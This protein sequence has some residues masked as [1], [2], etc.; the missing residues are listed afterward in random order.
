M[1]CSTPITHPLARPL[2]ALLH[3]RAVDCCEEATAFVQ[4]LLRR[5]AQRL[6]T[7]RDLSLG[8]DR[9]GANARA[10]RTA[11]RE[12]DRALRPPSFDPQPL[13]RLGHDAGHGTAIHAVGTMLVSL[14]NSVSPRVSGASSCGSAS[15]PTP[16]PNDGALDAEHRS[17]T[18][19]LRQLR[20][21]DVVRTRDESIV[22]R[23]LSIFSFTSASSPHFHA[24]LQPRL[25]MNASAATAR[26]PQRGALA[27]ARIQAAA[28][29]W[30]RRRAD[31]FRIADRLADGGN[32]TRSQRRRGR[33]RDP[34]TP[35]LF[36]AHA[37]ETP[38][39]PAK[40]VTDRRGS[41]SDLA[42][43][44]DRVA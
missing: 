32:A 34:H 1:H 39:L 11:N 8:S 15:S 10:D 35:S 13:V 19:L 21:L 28:D 29:A 36:E 2:P 31:A 24:H 5:A 3:D 7:L 14:P 37:I 9:S 44:V 27:L 33:R 16:C 42:P 30:R 23:W 6:A 38:T 43:A 18:A 26:F 20:T 22:E 40:Q 25:Q 17:P 4:S 41:D 12:A